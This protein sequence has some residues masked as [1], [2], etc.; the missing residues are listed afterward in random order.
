M[1]TKLISRIRSALGVELA[2]RTLFEA[3]TVAQLASRLSDAQVAREA[4][5]PMARPSQI[6]LSFAQRRLWFLYRLDGPSSTYNIPVAL[7]LEGKLDDDALDQA[8]LDLVARH[9]SL[10]T[11]FPQTEDDE[12]QQLILPPEAVQSV[13]QVMDVSDAT[14]T[15]QLAKAASH[16]FELSREI[17][18][19]AWLFHLDA[20]HHV[21][22][23]LCHHIASDGWSWAPLA[24]DVSTAYAA[25]SQGKP[26]AWAPLPVQYADYT[27]WQHA[28]LGHESNSNSLVAKQLSYWQQALAGLPEQLNLP[29]DRPRPTISSFRGENQ[30]F[31]IDA[32]LHQG[33]VALAREG[34]TSLFMVLQAALS[35]LFTRMGAGTD[36]PL[37]SPI[38]GR[39]DEALDDLV[40]FFVNT[41]VLRTD[42]SGNPSF[43]ELLARVRE[44]SLA[45]Y[46]HQDLPFERLV[47]VLN[48]VRSMARHPLFQVALVLQNNARSSFQLPGIEV[49]G[50]PIAAHTAKFDLSFSLVERRGADGAAQGILGEIEFATDLFDRATVERLAARLQRMLAA[51]AADP[52]QPIGAIEIL[53]PAERQQIL[54]GW[55][56]TAHPVPQATLPELFEQQVA[57]TPQATALVFEDTSLTYA[58][59]NARANRLAHHLIA[60]SVRRDDRVAIC[61][62][63]GFE[64]VIALLAVLKAGGVYV[65]LDPSYP[66]NRLRL[67]LEDSA[68]KVL[69][70]QAHIASQQIDDQGSSFE[71][72]LLDGLDCPWSDCASSNPEPVSPDSLAY[73]IY[74]SGSTGTPKGVLVQHRSLAA[75]L[76]STRHVL[77]FSAIDTIPNLASRSFDISLLE[78]LLP[79]I[80]GGS[81]LLLRAEEV[82]D[83]KELVAKTKAATFFHAVPSLME[84]WLTFLGV[85]EAKGQYPAL[86]TVLVG[87]DAVSDKLLQKIAAHF[88]HVDVVELYGP[89]EVTIFGTTYHSDQAS[90][91][92]AIHCIGKPTWNTQAYVL[93]T[94]LRPVPAGVAGELYIAGA[95][96]AR[97]YLNRPGLSAERFVANP[98]G[99]PGS[100]MYRTGDLARW[101]ADGVLD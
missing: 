96:L 42:T 45:A 92:A 14:L 76:E 73:L 24:H 67:M 75:K 97:G 3:P 95:G 90:A 89:T 72:L 25:R 44:T 86:R 22:L 20:E 6:P 2:I 39:T 33:L 49:S 53:E 48:P 61:I 26:P 93:D 63:H 65:P 51:I 46:E 15:Y 62:E 71:T 16:G 29:T 101:R 12:P 81:T 83:I 18:F 82:P 57:R 98:F 43:R 85:E 36:I 40:G 69:V 55:N 30:S 99:P 100:R 23:L 4:L 11:I 47:E 28:L 74:T 91:H 78:M 7:H 87:G 41:L 70:T 37:G 77:E 68:P 27:L 80:S 13:L 32:N 60:L 64:T 5:R 52:A 31:V 35:A 59:L 8:L 1:A 38:A 94:G 66:V 54:L 19:R 56:D 9:E 34:Q 21:L 10:R 58:E 79:L 17:P 84:A 88:P 50:E